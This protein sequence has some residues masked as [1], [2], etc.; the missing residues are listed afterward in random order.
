MSKSLGVLAVDL[1]K[2]Q[3]RQD[4]VYCQIIDAE[5]ALGLIHLEWQTSVSYRI[6]GAIL[7]SK[8]NL[9]LMPMGIGKT[10]ELSK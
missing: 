10:T 7:C 5:N 1:T 8:V 6:I 2:E 3:Q 4:E 9:F